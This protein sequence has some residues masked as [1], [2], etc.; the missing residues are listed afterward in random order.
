[1]RITTFE[2]FKELAQ[3]G[4]FVPVHKEIVADLLTPV[5]AFLKIA[6]HSDYAFLLESV[7][8]GEHVGRY[9]FLGKD[10]FLILRSR[11]GKTIVDRAGQTSESDK[12]FIATLRELMASF[13]VDFKDGAAARGVP[14]ATAERVFSQVIAFSEFGF[15]KSHAAAF[16]LLAYQSAWLRH[17]HPAEYYT[18][19]FNNQPMGFY[20]LD[21]LGRD[22]KRNGIEIRLPDVNASDVW[23]T[24]EREAGSGKRDAGAVR[25]GLGF[26]RDWSEETATA[27]VLER[28]RNGRYCS[29]G[30]FVRRAPPQLK[31]TG[32]ENLVWVGGCDGFGLTRRELLWQV[33]LW[34]PPKAERGD[35]AR[36]R[37][38]TELPLDHP[39]AGLRFGGMEADERMLAEYQVLGF[40]ASGHPLALIAHALPPGVTRSDGLPGLEH[41]ARVAVAGLVVARQ[42][43]ETAK[44]FIFVLLED[45]AGMVNVIV[46][47]DVYE[48]YRV[49]VRGEPFLWV[50]GKL[51]KDDGVVNVLA[52]SVIGLRLDGR[53]DRGRGTSAT[54]PSPV[55]RP[56]SPYS[57]LKS[58]RSVTPDSKDWG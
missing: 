20:S 57:F 47:P 29:L 50:E 4:T 35:D 1:M 8:G 23:C 17:Y 32:I 12:P 43:P 13:W 19:L 36:G 15:P 51:A 31:R 38:Q 39:H 40:T 56:S 34:L 14:E 37:R 53:G 58:L 33:G 10:P 49:T 6:E 3:R 26:V 28:E 30:D 25:V 2:E 9:S 44:G 45:E 54:N 21:A 16:G 42:R 48:R 24:V 41:N 46:R 5:S 22:A 18:G 52:E 11:E 7:E 55:P 27:V